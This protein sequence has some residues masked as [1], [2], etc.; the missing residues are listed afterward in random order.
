MEDHLSEDEYHYVLEVGVTGKVI[1]GRWCTDSDEGHPDFLW[2]PIRVSTSSY[3]RNPNVSLENVRTLLGLSVKGDG[4]GGGGTSQEFASSAAV[5]IPDANP[6]GASSTIVVSGVSGPGGCS[7][8]V[9]I[10]HTYRG[11]LQVILQKDGHDLRTLHDH[12]GGSADNLVDTYTISPSELGADRNGAYTLEVV[13]NAA[14]DTGTLR[15]W[16]LVF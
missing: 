5:E 10:A 11:D 2:A 7:V 13:D 1:G 4:G 16:K 3:G 9:D 14:D 8:S 15:S 12:T 6:A